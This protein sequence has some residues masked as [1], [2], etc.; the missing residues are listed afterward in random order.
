[1]PLPVGGGPRFFFG[2][3]LVFAI[4]R[5]T[6]EAGRG[7][8]V[9]SAPALT[10]AT[11]DAKR[12]VAWS[13]WERSDLQAIPMVPVERIELPTFGLQNRCST[14]ELNRRINFA[15]GPAKS[16]GFRRSCG[17]SNIRLA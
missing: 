4:N 6:I 14:A 15:S 11:K 7:E 13:L 3:T 9:T 5:G 17:R 10:R 1:M 12:G 2:T 16:R 8:A